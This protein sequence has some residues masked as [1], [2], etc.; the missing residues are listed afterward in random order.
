MEFQTQPGNEPPPHLHE[1]EH[2][3]FYMLE[4]SMEV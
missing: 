2:E 4:G 3:L 1:W